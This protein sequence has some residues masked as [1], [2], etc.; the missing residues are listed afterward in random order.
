M[1]GLAR[2][3]LYLGST[4]FGGPL[5]LIELMRRQYVIKEQKIS[6]VEFDQVFA[7]VKAMPG[8]VAFQMAVFLGQRFFGFRGGLVAGVCLLLPA[9]ILMLLVIVRLD[10]ELEAVAKHLHSIPKL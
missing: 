8:P 2:Y 4:G 1:L 6:A 5:V 7:L 10:R 3:F 9:F